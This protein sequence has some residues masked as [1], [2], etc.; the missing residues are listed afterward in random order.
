MNGIEE[1]R[2]RRSQ[3]SDPQVPKLEIV[4]T[5]F[6]EP[7]CPDG[8]CNLEPSK[9]R[10]QRASSQPQ[11]LRAPHEPHQNHVSANGGNSADGATESRGG[12]RG[13]IRGDRGSNDAALGPF[14]STRGSGDSQAQR[15][16]GASSVTRSLLDAPPRQANY[17]APKGPPHPEDHPEASVVSVTSLGFNS[18]EK[19]LFHSTSFNSFIFSAK[20]NSY[21]PS[22]TLLYLKCFAGV[23]RSRRIAQRR[24][25]AKPARVNKGTRR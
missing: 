13:R 8:W 25:W 14:D 15:R 21:A 5:G 24:R 9:H 10:Q 3:P 23:R 6:N 17:A 16:H 19:L 1:A 18:R 7:S 12:T 4:G 20:L 2:S 11:Q 22:A